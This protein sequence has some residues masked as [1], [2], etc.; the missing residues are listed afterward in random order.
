MLDWHR[1]ITHVLAVH[2]RLHNIKYGMRWHAMACDSIWWH[3]IYSEWFWF[4][5]ILVAQMLNES[6]HRLL[7]I[8][9]FVLFFF[10]KIINFHGNALFFSHYFTD[11]VTMFGFILEFY[12]QTWKVIDLFGDTILNRRNVLPGKCCI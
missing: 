11:I 4:F 10:C 5:Q 3:E 12:H 6:H 8:W 9:M 7:D 2:C 1:F